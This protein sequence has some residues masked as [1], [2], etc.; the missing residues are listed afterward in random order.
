[1]LPPALLQILTTEPWGSKASEDASQGSVLQFEAEAPG[2]PVAWPG[3]RCVRVL[4]VGWELA[5]RVLRPLGPPEL[6]L[7]FH[8]SHLLA[9]NACFLSWPRMSGVLLTLCAPVFLMPL[10]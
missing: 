2:S 7:T 3:L 5:P 4:R 9:I 6:V 8:R 10:L 1:M